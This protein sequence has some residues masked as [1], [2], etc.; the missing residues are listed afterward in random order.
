MTGKD[1]FTSS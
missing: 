1:I